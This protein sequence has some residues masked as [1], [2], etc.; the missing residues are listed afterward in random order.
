MLFKHDIR[1]GK[2]K[3]FCN[4]Y[5]QKVIFKNNNNDKSSTSYPTMNHEM[6]SSY[7]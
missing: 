2:R 3:I 4:F 5:R 1:E 6:G 7:T